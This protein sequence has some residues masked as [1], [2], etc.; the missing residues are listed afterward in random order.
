MLLFNTS[1]FRAVVLYRCVGVARRRRAR[2]Y[3]MRTVPH[4]GSSEIKDLLNKFNKL[5][6]NN[7]A[8]FD[9]IY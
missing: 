1:V 7:R 6:L 9:S 3:D 2:A 4:S 5:A 8:R